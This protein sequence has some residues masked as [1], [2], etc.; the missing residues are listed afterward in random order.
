MTRKAYRLNADYGCFPLWERQGTE[1]ANLD[2]SALAISRRLRARLQRWTA[3]FE[4]T[5]DP[6]CPEQSGFSSEALAQA[7]DAQ[8]RLIADALR[9]ELAPASVEFLLCGRVAR[10]SSRRQ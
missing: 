4:S 7:F 9:D 8:G 10:K 1:Y 3:R 2:P 5:F 6:A